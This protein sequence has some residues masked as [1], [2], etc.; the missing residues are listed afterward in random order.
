M[1]DLVDIVTTEHHKSIIIRGSLSEP[2]TS[3]TALSM[4]VCTY[5]C[6]FRLTTYHKFQMS[7]YKILISHNI[8]SMQCTGISILIAG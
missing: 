1:N 2:H 8:E 6:L 4:C 7:A 5:L 3:V